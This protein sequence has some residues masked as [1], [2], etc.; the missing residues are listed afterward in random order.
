MQPHTKMERGTS[1]IFQV[2]QLTRWTDGQID[3]GYFQ[4]SSLLYT[5]EQN[6]SIS[7]CQ[8]S[9]GYLKFLLDSVVLK[10][11]KSRNHVIAQ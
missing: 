4:L 11:Y 5:G 3:R 10:P 9:T 7:A 1:H 6:K 8:N 2:I